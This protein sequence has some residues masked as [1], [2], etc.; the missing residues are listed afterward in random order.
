MIFDKISNFNYFTNKVYVVYF[1][2]KIASLR[3]SDTISEENSV[4]LTF[5]RVKN[6]INI[7]FNFIHLSTN[8]DVLLTQ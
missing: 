6:S 7:H 4:L 8:K 5:V 3:H 2:I 1:L